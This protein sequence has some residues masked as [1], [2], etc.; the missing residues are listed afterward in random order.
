MVEALEKLFEIS[1]IRDDVAGLLQSALDN[2]WI[3]AIS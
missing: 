2:G 3:R 1:G